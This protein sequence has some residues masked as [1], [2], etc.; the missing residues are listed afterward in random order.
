VNAQ[1][2]R[3]RQLVAERASGVTGGPLCEGC[4]TERAHDW[5]HRIARGRGGA[6]CPTNGLALCRGCHSFQHKR[7]IEAE[8]MGWTVPTGSDPATV[9]VWTARWGLVYL[10]PDG[11]FEIAAE[12]A[13]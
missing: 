11:G 10:L 7:P 13:S 9:P 4:L 1:E 5:A 6:W 12:R 3:A 8:A 2:K